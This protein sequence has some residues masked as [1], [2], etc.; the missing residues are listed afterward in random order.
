MC[1]SNIAQRS[2]NARV[3]K[4]IRREFILTTIALYGKELQIY[5]AIELQATWG[6]VI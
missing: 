1:Y 2:P 3:K 6:D 4:N 5:H